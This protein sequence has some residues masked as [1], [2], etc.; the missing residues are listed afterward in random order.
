MNPI[1]L[2]LGLAVVIA[3]VTVGV[4]WWALGTD[5]F[6]KGAVAGSYKKAYNKWNEE[7]EEVQQVDN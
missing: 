5:I 7:D 1:S 4:M 3:V 6:W 2:L